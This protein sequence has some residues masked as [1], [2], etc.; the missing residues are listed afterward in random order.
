[1]SEIMFNFAHLGTRVG[2][3][4]DVT[5]LNSGC[6]C[7]GLD[8]HAVR[9]AF[10]A[11]PGV[12]GLADLVAARCPHV[13]AARPVFVTERHIE[14]MAQIIEAVETVVATPAY[15]TAA[16]AYA[17]EIARH[18]VSAA[19]SVFF[20]YDFHV[21]AH[22]I[23][24]IEINTNA[25][26][27]ML[28]AVMSRAQRACCPEIES[29]LP[30]MPENE[31]A[32]RRIMDMFRNEWLLAG[33]GRVLRTIA[34]VD[35]SPEQQYL[36]PEFLLFQDLF[37][38]HDIHAVISA[39][40]ELE[41]RAGRLWHGT[42]AIDMVYNRLT[43][44]DL[45]T[46]NS[47]ALRQAYLARAAVITPHPRAHALYA[48]KRNLAL[49]SDPNWLQ[50]TGVAPA[51][52]DILMAGIPH[53]EIVTPAHA[54]RLWS[55]RRR[56]F[57]KPA[58]GFG[59]RATY[60]GDKLTRRV[61]QEIVAGDYVAQALVSPGERMMAAAHDTLALKFDVRAYAYDGVLQ[62]LAARLYQGQTTNFRT[63]GG[64]FAPVYR[65]GADGAADMRCTA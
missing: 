17:P 49:L 19:R 37:Q 30:V 20:G 60:R 62:S 21:D 64:G 63:P 35:S 28:N 52:R 5:L 3:G 55:E 36:Y 18:E 33:D 6:F 12:P 31:A 14:R 8:Q 9:T 45:A 47:T 53:T 23:A 25:G 50:Q 41:W 29:V 58:A 1:M 44:F 42:T 16:L 51:T 56:L 32:E 57:F 34:I 7:I 65:V 40:E 26:G 46:P 10:E 2:C 27:A 11:Q 54:A 39:P 59:G 61:W 38:R 15:R 24:L 4:S 48:N 13:F 43:D 22:G